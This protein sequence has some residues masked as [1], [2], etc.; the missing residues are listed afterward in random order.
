MDALIL[1]FFKLE[2]VYAPLGQPY[3]TA[4][5]LHVTLLIVKHA[6]LQTHAK[7]VREILL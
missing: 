1:S 2:L 6:H 7:I 4:R 3:L 5:A